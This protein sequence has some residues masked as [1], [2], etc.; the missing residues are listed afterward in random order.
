[1]VLYP[2]L[3]LTA[4]LLASFQTSKRPGQYLVVDFRVCISQ[5]QEKFF[6]LDVS[7][8]CV[9]KLVPLG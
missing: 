2:I 7:L 9:S 3:N 4:C 8:V 6:T 1:M 5:E